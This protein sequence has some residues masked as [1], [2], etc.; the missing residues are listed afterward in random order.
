[1]C[2]Q[3][4]QHIEKRE[5][6]DKITKQMCENWLIS[7]KIQV[8]MAGRLTLAIAQS[9]FK[10]LIVISSFALWDSEDGKKYSRIKSIPLFGKIPKYVCSESISW[11]AIRKMYGSRSIKLCVIQIH[12]K[13]QSEFSMDR[14]PRH[15]QSNT[16]LIFDR[17]YFMINL[18]LIECAAAHLDLEHASIYCRGNKIELKMTDGCRK[19]V[20][21]SLI[22]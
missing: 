11:A 2:L 20:F 1:M 13:H 4:A 10:W 12:R 17:K 14:S 5:L 22:C 9:K 6:H 7:E 18:N 3:D 8:R 21:V 19:A 15:M 16:R